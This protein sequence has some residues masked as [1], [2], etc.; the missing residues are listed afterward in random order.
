MSLSTRDGN[1]LVG[2]SSLD[3]LKFETSLGVLQIKLAEV[4]NISPVQEQTVSLRLRDGTIL[5]GKIVSADWKIKTR[6]GEHPVDPANIQGL[7]I[8]RR[9][10]PAAPAVGNTPTGPVLAP[11]PK[12]LHALSLKAPLKDLRISGDGKKL[13]VLNPPKGALLIVN[14]ATVAVERELHVDPAPS[15][16]ALGPAEG[17]VAVGA[18]GKIYL[19]DTTTGQVARQFAIES[20]ITC[21]DVTG[22]DSIYVGSAGAVLEV[23][24][25]KQ[26]V[27]GK[28]E[29]SAVGATVPPTLAGGRRPEVFEG[30]RISP[31]SRYAVRKDGEAFRLG[32]SPAASMVS[33]VKLQPHE[34]ATFLPKRK[35]LMTFA[36]DGSMMVYSTE[37][38]ELEKQIKLDRSVAQAV[39]DEAA[40]RLYALAA[41][42][43][44][45]TYST[46]P[47]PLGLF[48]FELPD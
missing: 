20:E 40:A 18:K 34:A 14:A 32:K 1:V 47:A 29:R 30:L 31:D 4:E 8:T 6:F 36:R 37:S 7:S 10:A 16:L 33:M 3:V 19:V 38:W 45:P 17:T 12:L 25:S 9:A 21:L 27:V 26:A 28:Q 5:R 48:A 22:P 11:A 39:A 23:S 41:D 24:I 43:V 42:D 15:A 46:T 13:Y 2:T 44:R 35:Q